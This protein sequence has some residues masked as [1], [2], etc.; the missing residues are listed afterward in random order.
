MLCKCPTCSTVVADFVDVYDVF[1]NG[2]KR[3]PDVMRVAQ[4]W[5]KRIDNTGS[6]WIRRIGAKHWC[7]GFGLSESP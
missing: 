3:L 2:P 1:T 5:E 4:Y 7:K 6:M